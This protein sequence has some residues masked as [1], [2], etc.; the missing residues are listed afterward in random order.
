M[1]KRQK[2]VIWA[3]F[4]DGNGSWNKLGCD[5]IY[6]FGINDNPSWKN[7]F[8]IDLSITNL[9]LMKQ[10]QEIAEITGKPDIIIAHPPCESW[11]NADVQRRAY[12]D[13]K[14]LNH[15]D[16]DSVLMEVYSYHTYSNLNADVYESG[17]RHLLR[18]ADKQ[19]GRCLLGIGT[20]CATASIIKEFHP[21][22]AIV[23]NPQSSKIWEF[24]PRMTRLNFAELRTT[25]YSNWNNDFTT[26]PTTFGYWHGDCFEDGQLRDVFL[27]FPKEKTEYKPNGKSISFSKK[28][29]VSMTYDKKS[30][31]PHEL[32][33]WLYKCVTDWYDE[34]VRLS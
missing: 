16:M 13:I 4:D 23:E 17:K 34:Y 12:R 29:Y 15:R 32:I 11:S 7:Y 10:L 18:S 1:N 9:N 27:N 21:L 24:I 5:N 22:L 14:A 20:A 26:K 19:I 8:K 2:P 3:L 30:A 31:V 6:S 33:E 28:G 25:Y